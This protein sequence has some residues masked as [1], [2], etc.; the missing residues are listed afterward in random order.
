MIGEG[1]DGRV[2]CLECNKEFRGLA[3]HVSKAHVMSLGDYKKIHTLDGTGND[4]YVGWTLA[5]APSRMGTNAA[6][7]ARSIAAP[8]SQQGSGYDA[9]LMI[10]SNLS[11]AEAEQYERRY[12][13]LFKQADEDEALQ[14]HIIDIVLGEINVARYQHQISTI[15]SRLTSG[16]F[17]DKDTDRLDTLTNLVKKTQETNLKMMDSLNLTRSKKQKTQVSIE[18]TPSRFCSAYEKFILG[19][20]PEQMAREM[21]DEKESV[22]RLNAKAKELRDLAPVEVTVE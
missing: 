6:S 1:T 19:L 7:A 18:T 3:G 21:R 20:T 12:T 14:S 16:T 17:S 4:V 15:T 8:P 2:L 11:T 22:D 9:G 13:L 5:D 10:Q